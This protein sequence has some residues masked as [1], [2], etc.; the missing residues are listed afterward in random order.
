MPVS[1]R[2]SRVGGCETRTGKDGTDRLD[3]WGPQ[4]EH[5][6]SAGPPSAEVLVIDAEL[7]DQ[8]KGTR[9]R[10]EVQLEQPVTPPGLEAGR[11]EHVTAREK[12]RL[13]LCH[14]PVIQRT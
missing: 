8:S 4:L 12:P 14:A 5:H 2:W 9:R 1:T 6:S 11:L 13:R 3:G 10:K 7:F